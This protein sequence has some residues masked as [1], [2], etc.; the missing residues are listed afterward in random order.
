[1]YQLYLSR[2]YILFSENDKSVP[3]CPTHLIHVLSHEEIPT[4]GIG[5]GREQVCLHH[6]VCVL[7]NSLF[8]PSLHTH[9]DLFVPS[10][11]SFFLNDIYFLEPVTF[12][13][14]LCIDFKVRVIFPFN[15]TIKFYFIFFLKKFL[16]EICFC[17]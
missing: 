17:E 16:L 10:L 14:I 3:S 2:K 13:L 6:L 8:T 15:T 7:C 9:S 12:A 5:R 4:R 11:Q 1:M